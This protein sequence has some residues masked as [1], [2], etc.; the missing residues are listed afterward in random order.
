MSTIYRTVELAYT[1]D[2]H[3]DIDFPDELVPRLRVLPEG[4]MIKMM[5]AYDKASP[6]V[7][8][9]VQGDLPA[10]PAELEVH[11]ISIKRPTDMEY[12]EVDPEYLFAIEWFITEYGY[13]QME[14]DAFAYFNGEYE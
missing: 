3:L 10:D 7:F 12:K 13:D 5:Y 11:R 2:D 4:T 9:R 14:D 1:V 6:P 8:N